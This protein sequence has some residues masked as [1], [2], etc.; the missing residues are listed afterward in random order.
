[1]IFLTG[2]MGT[3][4]STVGKL[5]AA[6]L[7]VGFT[8]LDAMIVNEEGA[9]IPEIF[10]RQGEDYFRD[11]ESAMLLKISSLSKCV[12]AT[13]GGA[14]LRE[15]NRL[16]MGNV[17]VIVNLTASLEAISDRISG[18]TGRPLLD[19]GDT[20]VKISRL[21]IEREP[22]YRECHIQIDTTGKQPDD[23]VE[24]ILARL[25]TDMPHCG[26]QHGN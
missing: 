20:G 11:L 26:E 19:G 3:G 2:F 5:L 25:K 13:G 6:R 15:A 23:I 12:V 4:K 14:V 21:F 16:L 24:E 9:T 8:D 10:D 1:M 18:D 17:G 22:L 7:R